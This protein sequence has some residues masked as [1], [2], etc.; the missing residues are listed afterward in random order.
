MKD[1]VHDRFNRRIDRHGYGTFVVA[2]R[3]KGLEL[4]GQEFGR[5]EMV[6]PQREPVRDQGLVAPEIDDSD[7]M[8]RVDEDLA[9][10]ALERGAGD[11]SG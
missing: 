2:G 8:S 5:H 4:A 3:L 7:V 6:F 9:I 11:D 1:L 10:R